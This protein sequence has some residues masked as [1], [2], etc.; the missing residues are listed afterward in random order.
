MIVSGIPL[1]TTTELLW[2]SMLAGFKLVYI[3]LPHIG[4]INNCMHLQ[5]VYLLKYLIKYL[6]NQ[7]YS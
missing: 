6:I 4:Y 7:M 2:L 1:K 5:F 3:I